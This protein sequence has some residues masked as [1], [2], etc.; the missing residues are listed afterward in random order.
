MYCNKNEIL[1]IYENELFELRWDS[2]S[3][4]FATSR[5]FTA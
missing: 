4:S 3:D 2:S 5:P 1:M